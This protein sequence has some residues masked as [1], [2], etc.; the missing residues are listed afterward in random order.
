MTLDELKELRSK[1]DVS[2]MYALTS[3]KLAFGKEGDEY[4]PLYCLARTGESLNPLII[5]MEQGNVPFN[6]EIDESY[7][8]LVRIIIESIEARIE[9]HENHEMYFAFFEGAKQFRCRRCGRVV[10]WL[11][12]DLKDRYMFSSSAEGNEAEGICHECWAT[13]H[14]NEEEE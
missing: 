9:A 2:D 13:E 14:Q 1:F 6:A 4:F 3:C 5:E 8:T 12:P 11:H 7:R 10:G